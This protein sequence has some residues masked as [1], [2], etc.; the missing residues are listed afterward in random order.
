MTTARLKDG[1]WVT[2]ARLDGFIAAP[3]K[4]IGTWMVMALKL[5]SYYPRGIAVFELD[6]HKCIVCA[7]GKA[8]EQADVKSA[9]SWI[10]NMSDTTIGIAVCGSS[11]ACLNVCRDMKPASVQEHVGTIINTASRLSFVEF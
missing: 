11:V 5:A 6:N 10:R 1:Y 2:M 8:P 7:P 9:L 4:D 3:V